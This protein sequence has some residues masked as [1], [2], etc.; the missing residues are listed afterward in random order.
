MTDTRQPD[1]QRTPSPLFTA[2]KWAAGLRQSVGRGR[3]ERRTAANTHYLCCAHQPVDRWVSDWSNDHARGKAGG[4]WFCLRHSD[5]SHCFLLVDCLGS[6]WLPEGPE[7][8]PTA[9]QID[10]P[11]VSTMQRR[12]VHRTRRFPLPLVFSSMLPAHLAGV[13][14]HTMA[15]GLDRPRDSTASNIM[16]SGV[17][18]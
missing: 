7:S 12:K 9:T 5:C 4:R 11:D 6:W 3:R 8:A 1:S 16:P 2:R 14:R 17:G 10:I 13:A 18:A 15:N